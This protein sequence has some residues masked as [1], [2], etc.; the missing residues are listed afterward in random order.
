MIAVTNELEQPLEMAGRRP[1]HSTGKAPTWP[2]SFR[3][4]STACTTTFKTM[5]GL[6]GFYLAGMWTN[7]AGGIPGAAGVGR[8]VV[9]ILCDEDRRRFATSTS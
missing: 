5:T 1:Y 4:S 6:A 8:Q 9:Q 2:G 7:P 3:Q